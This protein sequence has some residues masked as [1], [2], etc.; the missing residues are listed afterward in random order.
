MN[1]CKGCKYFK[2]YFNDGTY[3]NNEKVIEIS[4]QLFNTR[5]EQIEDV[6]LL[7]LIEDDGKSISESLVNGQLKA[8]VARKYIGLTCEF[9]EEFTT[10]EVQEILDEETEEI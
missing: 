8:V 4:T 3:C 9:R 2:S 10:D 1:I 5:M 7:P 6:K